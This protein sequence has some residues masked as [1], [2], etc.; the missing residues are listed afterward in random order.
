MKSCRKLP[1][2]WL[3]NT[4]GSLLLVPSHLVPTL[5]MS[6]ESTELIGLKWIKRST[7]NASILATTDPPKS[8]YCFCVDA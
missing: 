8:S 7:I 2:Y 1:K 5:P 4:V 6:A 3:N